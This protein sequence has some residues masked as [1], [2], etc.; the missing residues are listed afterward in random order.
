MFKK[1]KF[2]RY[3]LSFLTLSITVAGLSVDAVATSQIPN[4]N[5]SLIPNNTKTIKNDDT[6]N[7]SNMDIRSSASSAYSDSSANNGYFIYDNQTSDINYISYFG[8]LS[9][10][11]NVV[12]SPFITNNIGSITAS[13]ITYLKMKFI[14]QRNRIAVYGIANG[15]SFLFQLNTDGTEYFV[16]GSQSD[17]VK[18]TNS[19]LSSQNNDGMVANV[20]QLS[21]LNDLTAISLPSD[22]IGNSTQINTYRIDLDSYNFTPITISLDGYTPWS[23]S[24]QNTPNVLDNTYSPNQF[25]GIQNFTNSSFVLLISVT[26]S[27]SSNVYFSAIR[28]DFNFT[29]MPYAN[30]KVNSWLI[31]TNSDP[32]DYPDVFNIKRTKTSYG[33]YICVLTY[34]ITP[35]E[36]Q[37][38]TGYNTYFVSESN[39]TIRVLAY[40]NWRSNV[41]KS[42][43]NSNVCAYDLLFNPY[44][45]SVFI[46]SWAITSDGYYRFFVS[47]LDLDGNSGGGS[48]FSS[49]NTVYITAQKDYVISNANYYEF[50]FLPILDS[51]ITNPWDMSYLVSFYAWD[52]SKNQISTGYTKVWSMLMENG[53]GQSVNPFTI[54]E[55]TDPQQAVDGYA[56]FRTTLPEDVTQDELN[57]L[58]Y[59][60]SVDNTDRIYNSQLLINSNSPLTYDNNEG[61]L[62]GTVKLQLTKWWIGGSQTYE[63][64]SINLNLSNFATISSLS[65]ELVVSNGVD[66]SKWNN[67]TNLKATKFPSEVTKDDILN[68]FVVMGSAINITTDN[69]SFDDN[70]VTNPL[71][72]VKS[73]DD[74]G[75]L[76]ISYDLSSVSSASMTSSNLSGEYVFTGFKK[77]QAFSQV[78]LN[79]IAYA[80]LMQT[81]L[82]FQVTKQDIINC[83]SL[84]SGYSTNPDDWQW[85]PTHVQ[86]TQDFINDQISG[87]LYGQIKYLKTSDFGSLSVPESTYTLNLDNTNSTGFMNIISY[88]SNSVTFNQMTA[89]SLAGSMNQTQVNNYYL[90]VIQQSMTITNNWF[91]PI[92]LSYT[93]N[94][95][96]STS[97][98]IV[99]TINIPQSLNVT[100]NGSPLTFDST[101]ISSLLAKSS[102]IFGPQQVSFSYGYIDYSW[103]YQISNQDASYSI[104]NLLSMQNTQIQN[105]FKD[106]DYTLPSDFIKKFYDSDNRNFN[107]FQDTFNLLNPSSVN[108]P[109]SIYYFQIDSVQLV[110]YNSDGSI[111]ANYVINYPNVGNSLNNGTKVFPSIKITGF[112]KRVSNTFIWV[113]PLIMILILI[114]IAIIITVSI[115]RIKRDKFLYS[116]D[117]KIRKISWKYIKK[118]K[119]K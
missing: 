100:I 37:V 26:S 88:L 104:Q 9:W 21:I 83:L 81:K 61:T 106:I 108:N 57:N 52:S 6:A 76:D 32:T 101:W 93:I 38:K 5:N 86:G 7:I 15:I 66:S 63:T 1:T 77:G 4:N 112:K 40:S 34:Q 44:T 109:S 91:D 29:Y 97:N 110:A 69:I 35:L 94:Q 90:K 96:L 14:S 84:S 45:N 105:E 113:V 80:K 43:Q 46:V 31:G 27:S 59:L 70:T 41:M 117:A 50:V 102:T 8:N 54:T 71:I 98:L 103:N 24:G 30:A 60:H 58:I 74:N 73:D 13:Q 20:L 85:T 95:S 116:K 75:T 64:Y 17:S 72:T 89:N 115:R 68:Y 99:A 79:S 33:N 51:S 16:N 11:Y 10:T 23:S 19:F 118:M 55:L 42:L 82:P 56:P 25:I 65:F 62:S 87:T 2:W 92:N 22:K 78:T 114:I 53:T 36:S 12:N 39:G 18:Y 28:L 119:K 111:T 3:I 47:L 67:I 107:K 48:Y 49:G